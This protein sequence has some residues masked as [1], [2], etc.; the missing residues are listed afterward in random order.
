LTDDD[1]G[2][3]LLDFLALRDDPFFELLDVVAS[4]LELR[5][6]NF[7][8]ERRIIGSRGLFDSDPEE[9]EPNDR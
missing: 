8:I 6:D 1:V 4:L 3:L 2:H 7:R 5:L 9:S